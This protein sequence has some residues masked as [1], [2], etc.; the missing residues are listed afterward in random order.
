MK[1]IK[2]D[3]ILLFALLIPFIMTYRLSPGET[4]YWLFGLIF[5]VLFFYIIFDLGWFSYKEKTLSLI[6]NILLWILIFLSIGSAYFAAIVVRHQSAPQY[7]VHDIILQ[8]EAAIRFF[9]HGKNPYA[10]TYFGTP[11]EKWHYS[12]TE[13]NP[14]LYHFVM[15]PFYL[16]FPI[17]FY[18]VMGHTV[19]FFDARIPLFI[20]FIGL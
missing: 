12:D 14:A 8:Q 6:K 20:L 10:V 17:P 3:T 7:N 5:L 19:G 11:L 18:L 2:L 15:Q 4:P 16:L 1:N 9:L 13:V